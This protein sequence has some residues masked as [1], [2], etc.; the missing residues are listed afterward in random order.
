MTALSGDVKTA[1]LEEPGALRRPPT[2]RTPGCQAWDSG[3]VRLGAASVGKDG[4]GG[5]EVLPRH[6][7]ALEQQRAVG[8]RVAQPGDDVA[9]RHQVLLSQDAL[10]HGQEDV[11]GF[12]QRRSDVFDHD[13]GAGAECGGDLAGVRLVRADG[14]DDSGVR[15]QVGVEQGR[16]G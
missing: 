16:A 12:A 1:T 2:P 8:G 10:V 6:A 7:H 11:A 14:H 13:G 4:L 15:D 5:D 3:L 9:H